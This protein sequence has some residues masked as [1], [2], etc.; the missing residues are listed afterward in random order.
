M[1]PASAASPWTARSGRI[2]P[3]TGRALVR[4][5][6]ERE[7]RL[8][9]D[10]QVDQRRAVLDVPDVELD[11]VRP[12]QG[13]TAVHL[14]PAGDSREYVEPTPLALVVALDL[15]PQRRS[16]SDD[17]HVAAQ[18]VPELRQLVE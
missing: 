16:R 7:R 17:A 10:L 3:A 13:G 4:A 18:D 11:A 14:R 12:R 5:A 2:L 8:G 6:E 15:V 9:E 1:R